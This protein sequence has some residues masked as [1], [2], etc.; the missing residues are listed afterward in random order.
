VAGT[1]PM[2]TMPSVTA[3]TMKLGNA[4]M[5]GSL[6]SG[7][8]AGASVGG[9]SLTGCSGLGIGVAIAVPP[10]GSI[11]DACPS[12]RPSRVLNVSTP[13]GNA[14]HGRRSRDFGHGIARPYV[15]AE[16]D[17]PRETAS[18]RRQGRGADPVQFGGKGGVQFARDLLLRSHLRALV[19]P[20]M[21]NPAT[22]PRGIPRRNARPPSA[23]RMRLLPAVPLAAVTLGVPALLAR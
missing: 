4:T 7:P 10:S 6:A 11:R 13:I 17:R 19:W 3:P 12:H 20:A 16:P 2:R 14:R 21:T 8:A 15:P 22:R 9:T 1:T 18:Q 5:D 23:A